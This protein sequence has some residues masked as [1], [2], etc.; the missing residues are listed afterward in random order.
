MRTATRSQGPGRDVNPELPQRPGPRARACAPGPGPGGL[1]LRPAPAAAAHRAG[2]RV[3][4]PPGLRPRDSPAH[5]R[6]PPTRRL[7]SAPRVLS[8]PRQRGL[9]ARGQEQQTLGASPWSGP[10]WRAELEFSRAGRRGPREREE[11]PE[12]EERVQGSE[13]RGRGQREGRGLRAAP[14]LPP[15]PGS[16][17]LAS[18][19]TLCWTPLS[20]LV[21]RFRGSCVSLVLGLTFKG[22]GFPACCEIRG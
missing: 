21:P 4:P 14:R 5:P 17:T 7:T 10:A 3:R 16:A 8:A 12:E 1:A 9:L 11:K 19:G 20:S 22:A 13:G 18:L 2:R 15:R 6:L